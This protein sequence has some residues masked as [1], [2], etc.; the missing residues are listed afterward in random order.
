MSQRILIAGLGNI[1][2]GDDGFGVEVVR[3][4]STQGLSASVRVADFGIR[5]LH[6]A[7]ELLDGSYEITILVDAARMGDEPGTVYFIKPDIDTLLG[8]TSELPDAH[9]MD[10]RSVLHLLRSLGGK[11]GD[12]YVVGCEPLQL[13]DEIG[14]SKPVAAAVEEALRLIHERLADWE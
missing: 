1:F 5:A 14:L 12:L 2:L 4:L 9:A 7:Y 8:D 11:P 6:L 10:F 13:E 3:R